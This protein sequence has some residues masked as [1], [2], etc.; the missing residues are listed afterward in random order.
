MK[1]VVLVQECRKSNTGEQRMDIEDRKNVTSW[2][3]R[4]LYFAADD[5]LKFCCFFKNNK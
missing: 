4:H 5:N 3:K 1:A 2:R